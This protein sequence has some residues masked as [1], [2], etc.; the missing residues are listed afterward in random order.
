MEPDVSSRRTISSG[1]SEVEV[2]LDVED[3]AERP[4]KKSALASLSTLIPSSVPPVSLMSSVETVLSVQI[5][6]TVWVLF[7]ST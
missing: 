3:R 1:L 2:R 7:S 6:P 5:R 4:T